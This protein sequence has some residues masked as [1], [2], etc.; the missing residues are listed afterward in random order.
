MWSTFSRFMGWAIMILGGFM[1]W[2]NITERV[3]SGWVLVA[4]LTAGVLGFVGG[5]TYLLSFDG[6]TGLRTKRV[7]LAGWSGMLLSQMLPTSLTVMTL[8]LVVLLLPTLR[9]SQFDPAPIAN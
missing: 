4:I 9:G 7:R 3:F 5:L 1:F 2:R 6:P 8:P